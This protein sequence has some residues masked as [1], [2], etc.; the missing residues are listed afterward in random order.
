M[1]T[2]N[3]FINEKLK[4]NNQSKLSK[5]G[6]VD[7][8]NNGNDIRYRN[9]TI[10]FDS[11]LEE[12]NGFSKEDINVLLNTI[13]IILDHVNIPYIN[14]VNA[15]AFTI[16]ISC[17]DNDYGDKHLTYIEKTEK[18]RIGGLIIP[19][20]SVR[21]KK[22]LSGIGVEYVKHKN[23]NKPMN[24]FAIELQNFI[25]SKNKSFKWEEV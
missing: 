17:Y 7:L 3:N 14:V 12:I 25:Q 11:P 22:S 23:P 19:K 1:K 9:T 2:I 21:M 8:Y 10:M 13:E 16:I 15:S 6:L 20:S 18:S 24:K 4:L 5:T